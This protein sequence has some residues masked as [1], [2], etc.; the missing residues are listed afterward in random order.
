MRNE[1]VLSFLL[2]LLLVSATHAAPKNERERKVLGDKAKMDADDFWIY[3]DL[4][5]GQAAAKREGKPLMVVFRCI[6]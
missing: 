1:P 2:L 3:N 6:P 5:R 4:Q